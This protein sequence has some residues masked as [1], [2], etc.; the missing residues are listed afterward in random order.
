[1]LHQIQPKEPDNRRQQRIN[2]QKE[3]LGDIEEESPYASESE[4]IEN[5]E[6]RIP[7]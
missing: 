1:M 2:I 7:E 6:Q 3:E 4:K 5:S